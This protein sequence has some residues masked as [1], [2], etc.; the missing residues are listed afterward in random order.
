MSVEVVLDD[1]EVQ[2]L[3]KGLIKNVGEISE[4]GRRYVGLLSAIVF[5]DVIEHFERQEG[6]EGKWAPWSK[7]YSK[8]MLSIGKGNNLILTDT[9]RLRQGWQPSRYRIS[10]DGVLW[11]NPVSYAAQHDEGL[12]QYPQRRFAWIS[13]VAIKNIE[14]QT[15]KF[16]E[17]I[18]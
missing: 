7:R 6:P 1:K 8:Y 4:K 12:G 2:K 10:S 15:V 13:D 16:I 3:L 5:K 14:E 11:Y 9:G 17:D 18:K